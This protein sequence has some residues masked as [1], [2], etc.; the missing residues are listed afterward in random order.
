MGQRKSSEIA[1]VD[2]RLQ[3][4]KSEKILEYVNI[5]GIENIYQINNFL[6]C[7]NL[8]IWNFWLIF[9]LVTNTCCQ[10]LLNVL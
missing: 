3:Y 9:S 4:S 10:F 2:R 7:I 1:F 5:T 8:F 6:L